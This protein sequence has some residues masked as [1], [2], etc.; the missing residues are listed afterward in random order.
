[1][2][3]LLAVTGSIAAYKS[4]DLLR[5]LQRRGHAVR[6]VLTLGALEFV[7]PETFRYLGAEKVYLPEDDFNAATPGVPHVDLGKWADLLAVAPMSADTLAKLADGR[8]ADFLGSIFLAWRQNRPVLL[9]PAMNTMMWQ[10]PFTQEHVARL[11]GLAHVRVVDPAAGLLACGDEGAGKLMEVEDLADVIGIL[12]PLKQRKHHTLIT[13]GAT[14]APMD[15]VRFLTNPASGKTGVEL[16]RAYLAA[17]CEVTLL[18]GNPHI[19]GL[20]G[21]RAHP[22]CRVLETPTTRQMLA[23]ALEHLPNANTV[24]AAAAVADFEFNVAAD[25]V[26]KEGLR[27]LQLHPAAD[28]LA[29]MLQRRRPGQRFV[30]FAAETDTSEEVFRAKFARKPVDLMVAN[31]VHAGFHGPREGFGED[32][33]TYW[34]V[35]ADATAPARQLSKREL[36]LEILSRENWS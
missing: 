7:R 35:T 23:A 5:A 15:P 29:E 21:L 6:V 3:I 10:H 19:A 24:I 20:S 34:F 4:L 12:N 16:A 1:M 9:F 25:K 31:R 2:N 11:N 32:G 8:C 18:T 14:V 17:G 36:A 13:T 22:R 26:K 30:S 27:E 28:I 33:A